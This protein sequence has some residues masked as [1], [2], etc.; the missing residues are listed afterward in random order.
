MR[1]LRR[2]L[3]YLLPPPL[4]DGPTCDLCGAHA[5]LVFS[6]GRPVNVHLT[7]EESDKLARITRRRAVVDLCLGCCAR[8]GVD[9]RERFKC[10]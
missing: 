9:L 5:R 10:E 2:L 3:A 8:R 1:L 7:A 6:E 4:T